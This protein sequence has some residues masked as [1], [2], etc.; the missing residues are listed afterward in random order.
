MQPLATLLRLQAGY[1]RPR[2]THDS[3]DM[4]SCPVN[5]CLQ[6]FVLFSC[7]WQQNT[8]RT[9]LHV[10]DTPKRPNQQP[11]Q[12]PT[13]STMSPMPCKHRPTMLFIFLSSGTRHHPPTP[14]RPRHHQTAKPT[15]TTTPCHPHPYFAN[16]EVAE[17]R[18]HVSATSLLALSASDD[19][20]GTWRHFSAAFSSAKCYVTVPLHGPII[21]KTTEQC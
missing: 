8:Y 4:T 1:K 20:A 7:I 15:A 13:T 12:P 2:L 5:Q 3:L 16:I 21:F 10:R 14:A 17:K 19:I 6:H 11:R 9:T 18:F